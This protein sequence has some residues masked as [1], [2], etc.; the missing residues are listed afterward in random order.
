MYKY[1]VIKTNLVQVQSTNSTRNY[2]KQTIVLKFY[3]KLF[4]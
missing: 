4:E 2:S 1:H 3:V